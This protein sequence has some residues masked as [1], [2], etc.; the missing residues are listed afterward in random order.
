[1][2]LENCSD[3]M[4]YALGELGWF[5]W[6]GVSEGS[7]RSLNYWKCIYK[8]SGAKPLS[9]VAG[10]ITEVSGHRLQ[11]GMFRLYTKRSFLRWRVVQCWNRSPEVW[12][13]SLLGQFQSL[14]RQQ[15]LVPTL[16]SLYIIVWKN[17]LHRVLNWNSSRSSAF[18]GYLQ[19]APD[20][21]FYSLNSRKKQ[22]KL[23]E[24]FT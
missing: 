5:S 17:A 6:R 3:T 11:L 22:S 8:G 23:F 24:S 21:S 7:S 18:A 13:I 4:E 10:K 16:M 9:V 20:T 2:F 14:A 1:M 19:K 12:K 15:A